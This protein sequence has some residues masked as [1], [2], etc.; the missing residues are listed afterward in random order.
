M[1]IERIGL[2][3]LTEDQIIAVC[4]AA[5]LAARRIIFSRIPKRA[6]LDLNIT[7]EASFEEVLT[8]NVD[9]DVAL[10]PLCKVD[11]DDIVRVAVDEAFKVVDKMLR[12]F[13]SNARCKA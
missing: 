4:K 7:V 13:S 5:E 3:Q 12:E 6:I 9:V 2:P 11:V 10:S 8:F 1:E